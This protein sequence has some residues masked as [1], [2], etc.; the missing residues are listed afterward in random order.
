MKPIAFPEATKTLQRPAG[1]SDIECAPLPV[2]NDG[3]DCVSCW[4]P[5]WRELVSI[6][7]F[8]RVWVFVR[9]GY[10]QP[11]IALSAKKTVFEPVVNHE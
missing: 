9:S 2:F 8:R 3:K 5:S 1:V 10:S 7:I 6:L 4:R 11:A